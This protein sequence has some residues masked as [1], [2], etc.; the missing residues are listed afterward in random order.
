MWVHWI[1]N[2]VKVQMLREGH[3]NWTKYPSW[4]VFYCNLYCKRRINWEILSYFFL[5]SQ[6]ISRGTVAGKT[7]RSAATHLQP[8]LYHYLEWKNTKPKQRTVL[9]L[10]LSVALFELNRAIWQDFF[11]FMWFFFTRGNFFGNLLSWN[12]DNLFLNHHILTECVA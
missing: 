6:N 10:R 4:F 3:T 11:A 7:R 5:P 1:S 9:S 12:K 8:N 2:S